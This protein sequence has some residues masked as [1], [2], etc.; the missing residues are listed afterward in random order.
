MHKIT[1]ISIIA[2]GTRDL[3]IVKG[4]KPG[5]DTVKK[6]VEAD[7]ED[8]IYVPVGDILW[9]NITPPYKGTGNSIIMDI[10]YDKEHTKPFVKAMLKSAGTK[11]SERG[12]QY[13]A[14]LGDN[15][16]DERSS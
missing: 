2:N 12:D 6:M 13:D 3:C 14:C 15:Y 4:P 9:I 10:G 7:K 8:I 11:R 16:F 1:K 5:S